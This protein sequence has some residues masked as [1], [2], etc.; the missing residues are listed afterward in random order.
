MNSSWYDFLTPGFVEKGVL[1]SMQ[2]PSQE[3]ISDVLHVTDI[4]KPMTLLISSQNPPVA[5]NIKIQNSQGTILY[6]AN[7]VKPRVI[8][9]PDTYGDYLVSIK[10][11]SSKDTIVYISYGY[12]QTENSELFSFLWVLFI[13]SGNYLIIHTYFSGARSRSFFTRR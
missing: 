10:N 12:A 2:I 7:I 13:V 9:S 3:S 8:F 5:F 4:T 6:N 1:V 11:L